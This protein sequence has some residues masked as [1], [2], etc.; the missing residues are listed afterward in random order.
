MA[1]G[2]GGS[3]PQLATAQGS[4]LDEQFARTHPGS[5]ALYERACAVFPSGVTHDNRFLRPFPIYVTHAQGARK[6]DVDGHEYIDYW[7]GH[8]ALL[9][10]HNHPEVTRA[11]REQLA[12]GTHYGACHELEVQWGEWVQRLIPSAARVKFTSSG[13]EATLM[14][15]R[16]ARSYTGKKKIVKFEGHFHGWHDHVVEGVQPPYDVPVSPGLLE[17]II[18]STVLCPPNDAA[19]LE[20]VLAQERDI[21]CVIVEPTGASFGAIPTKGAFLHELRRLTSAYGVLLVFDEVITGFRVSPGGAQ[22]HYGVTPDLTTLAKI[23]AGGLPGGAVAGRRDILAFLEFRDGAWNRYRKIAHPGTF[24]ANPLSAAAGVAAL[25]LAA[26]GEAQQQADRLARALRSEL[27][28]VLARRGINWCVYGDFSGLH[29]L[30]NYEAPPGAT[31]DPE[32]LRY[33]HRRLKGGDPRL[34]HAFRVAM[35]LNGVDLPAGT[36]FTSAAHTEADIA[37]TVTAFDKALEM[38]QAQRLV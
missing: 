2:Q 25:Q 14:A 29:V 38:L 31:F 4:A 22:T 10:G 27:N 32:D 34:Q 6:W 24:N 26:T 9:L 5:R 7:M 1:E 3:R 23:L 15:L 20:R 33:D 17:E 36:A 18:G 13:T 11:V 30:M 19:A 28:G 8:G 12:R 21:A 16:L 35:L 37:A